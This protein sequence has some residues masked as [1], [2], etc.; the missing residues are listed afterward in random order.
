MA[1]RPTTL[2]PIPQSPARH[3][4]RG[5]E[6]RRPDVALSHSLCWPLPPTRHWSMHGFLDQGSNSRAPAFCWPLSPPC[7]PIGPRCGSPTT[8]LRQRGSRQRLTP[9]DSFPKLTP[10]TRTLGVHGE[11]CSPHATS[12]PP[13]SDCVPVHLFIAPTDVS[14]P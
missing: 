9:T 14:I 13:S 2:L 12:H 7:H 5:H 10:S 11:L 1:H 8:P 3:T 4:S 6:S